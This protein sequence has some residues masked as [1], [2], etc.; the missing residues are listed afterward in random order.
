MNNFK[1]EARKQIIAEFQLGRQVQTSS[2]AQAW[3][4]CTTEDYRGL[5]VHGHRGCVGELSAPGTCD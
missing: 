2:E 3:E 4:V 1:S 5:R